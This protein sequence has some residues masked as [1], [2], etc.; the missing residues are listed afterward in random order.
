M[1]AALAQIPADAAIVDL[2]TVWSTLPAGPLSAQD[3]LNAFK[4]EREPPGTP[5]FNSFYQVM[6][7]GSALQT[8]QSNADGGWAVMAPA[9]IDPAK[10]YVLAIQKRPAFH[11]TV[12]L[13]AGVTFLSSPLPVAEVWSV[14]NSYGQARQKAC[15]YMDS[16][17]GMIPGCSPSP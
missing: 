14:L 2:G 8:L 9:T 17:Q 3:F 5:G 7:S 6:I 16:D 15:Q 12:Y 4:V 1:R 11:P 10:T 13:P